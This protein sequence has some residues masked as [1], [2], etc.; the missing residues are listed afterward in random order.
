M[1][2]IGSKH[3]NMHFSSPD[4]KSEVKALIKESAGIAVATL[5]VNDSSGNKTRIK[6]NQFTSNKKI[7]FAR[8]ILPKDDSYIAEQAKKDAVIILVSKDNQELYEK[9][10]MMIKKLIG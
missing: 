6:E 9:W 7:S 1:K 4:S 5:E 2:K 10:K 8:D 3:A